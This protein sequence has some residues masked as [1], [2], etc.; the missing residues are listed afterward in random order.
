MASLSNLSKTCYLFWLVK[1]DV[2][3]Y[4]TV[5]VSSLCTVAGFD[6][7]IMCLDVSEVDMSFEFV[8]E[9]YFPEVTQVVT[10]QEFFEREALSIYSNLHGRYA[11]VNKADFFRIYALHRFGGFYCD[12]DTLALRPFQ[13]LVTGSSYISSED[14]THLSN[15]ILFAEKGHKAL[16]FMYENFTSRWQPNT[17]N[18]V[19]SQW[20]TELKEYFLVDWNRNHHYLIS[21]QEWKKLFYP[22]SG[23]V[24]DLFAQEVFS[25]HLWGTTL[26]RNNF[27]L[28]PDYVR[29][30]PSTLFSKVV[31]FLSQKGSIVCEELCR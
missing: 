26:R 11:V 27:Y 21:W 18:L 19:G 25:V 12:A 28:S 29:E 15:G 4:V 1:G 6:E 17:F 5:S 30:R 22:F 9:T 16:K 2:P 14:G 8:R 31:R 20:F 10:P 3:L 23:E 7:V 13:S 24:E